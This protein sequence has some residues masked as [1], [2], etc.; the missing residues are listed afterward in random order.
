M[1]TRRERRRRQR[2]RR[3][4]LAWAIIALASVLYFL[5]IAKLLEV[6]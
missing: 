4:E 3:E 5:A 1:Y 2:Q 6:L